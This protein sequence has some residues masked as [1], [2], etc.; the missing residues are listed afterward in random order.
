MVLKTGKWIAKH[1]KLIVA[2]AILL[3]VPSVIGIANTRINYD[4]LSYLPSTL[5][6]VEGQD[7]LV[8]EFGMGAFSMVVVE[9]MELK[10]V[11]KLKT[12]IQEIE[13]VKD[14]LWYDSMMDISV[15]TSMLPSELEEA[16]FNG[17][18]TMM[19]ALFDNTTSSDEAMDAVSSMR[20]EVGKQC[21]ISGMT[22]VVTD[23]KN[24]SL[25]EMPIY[26]V[27]AALMSLLVLTLTME[28]L[29]VPVLF[30]LS[31]GIAILYNLG[32]NVFIGEIS[33][34][35][36][37]LTAI[38]QLGV[39]MDYSIFLLNSYEDNKIRYKNDKQRAMAHAISNTFKSVA[40]SS[41]TTI[42][43][44]AALCFMTFAL[45]RDIGIVMSKGVVIGVICCVTLLPAMILL[46]DKA[47]EKTRHKAL[48]PSLDKI[49][50]FLTKHYKVWIV[51]FLLMLF[52][53]IYGNNHT[54]IYYNIDKS[55]PSTLPS[56]VSNKRL[57]DDFHMNSVHMVLLQNGLEAKDKSQMLSQIEEVDGVKWAIG[58]NSFIG[59]SFPSSMI[60]DDIRTML[61]S[62]NYE[63]QFVC[64][65]Y[66]AATDE[67]NAQIA[68]IDKIVKSYSPSSMVIGEAPLTKDLADVTDVDLKN[69][70]IASMAAIFIIIMIVF[71]S[72]S[73]PII[74]VA[75][76]EF[77]ICVNM[78]V[79]Y[80]QGIT[81]PF[82]ASIVIG[83]IQLGATVDYAILMTS[84][85]QKERQRGKNKKES[86]SIAH[87]TS[88]KS[89][90]ISGISFFAATF[91][92]GLYSEIDMISSIC[93]LLS[94]GAIISTLVV[95]LVLP[96]MFMIFDA[97]ICR[98]S[99][100]FLPKKEEVKKEE[101]FAS[102]K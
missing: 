41:V 35:T 85:Y 51:V 42:A 69:V 66:K 89:I 14:V 55:L 47:I 12:K 92:V 50:A 5:E 95:I 3:L 27:I 18:A 101:C 4:I 81:L 40:G 86:I 2:I 72:I 36:M 80:Y 16:F 44:F 45:G 64:S 6:T 58:M 91:G 28:S 60:P 99:V 76:I 53:A 43:G 33:Y 1:T 87:R 98:T 15:P 74:L 26:I 79:P 20:S 70:N 54:Q 29:L 83:T 31:I 63:L 73:L 34:I 30:L 68:E 39:T 38:L 97:I 75:V 57:E 62:D 7:I 48:I 17:N 25:K 78:A 49:S 37:A 77:A 90:L 82:V 61:Q 24:I 11:S 22:G 88:M 71:K 96:A 67:V 52:P 94:R 32:S 46:C 13:H 59:G 8:D 21:F 102:T 93:T 65:D 23:I 10:D 56:A 84:R 19:I 9:D 100:G